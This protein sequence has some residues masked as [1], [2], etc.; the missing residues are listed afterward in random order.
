MAHRGR[1]R[2][3]SLNVVVDEFLLA[4][5]E[6][7]TGNVQILS[8]TATARERAALPAVRTGRNISHV[9]GKQCP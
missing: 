9:A 7:I 1:A 6:E 8:R 3:R 2:R 5:E 4:F